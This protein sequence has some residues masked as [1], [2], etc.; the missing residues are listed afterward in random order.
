[1]KRGSSYSNAL[2]MKLIENKGIMIKEKQY[3]LE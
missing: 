3:K 1:M 2:L